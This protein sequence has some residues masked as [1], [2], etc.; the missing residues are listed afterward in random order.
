MFSVLG[1]FV[2]VLKV[3][4]DEEFG[5]WISGIIFISIFKLVVFGGDSDLFNNVW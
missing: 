1:G 3:I 4:V 5:G 2:F